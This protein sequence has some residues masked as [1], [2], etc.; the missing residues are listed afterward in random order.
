MLACVGGGHPGTPNLVFPVDLTDIA[1]CWE[2]CDQC[3]LSVTRF[4]WLENRMALAS[5]MLL[6]GFQYSPGSGGISRLASTLQTCFVLLS[7]GFLCGG[8]GWSASPLAPSLARLFLLLPV[9]CGPQGWLREVWLSS[10]SQ[11][12]LCTFLPNWSGHRLKEVEQLIS[13]RKPSRE[14]EDKPVSDLSLRS[15]MLNC[16]PFLGQIL[17]REC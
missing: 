4:L 14:R 7:V 9:L 3:N 13:Y 16:F 1:C 2:V 15:M 5:P 17:K 8:F 10:L 6:L 11:L 12:L